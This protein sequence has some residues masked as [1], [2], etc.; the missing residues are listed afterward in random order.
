M[1]GGSPWRR[2]LVFSLPL[3]GGEICHLLYGMTDAFILGRVLG[4]GAL[5]AAGAASSFVQLVFG[6]AMGLSSGFTVITAQRIGSGGGEGVRR[7]VAAG[8][9]LS[10]ILSLVFTAVLIPL[11]RP[12]L[13]LMNTP[14]EIL[15]DAAAYA[16]IIIGGITVSM[17]N[18]LFGG[19][20][21]AS[22]DSLTPLA[23]L[24]VS[25]I[26]NILL[27]VLLVAVIPWGV[28]GAALATVFSQL[29]SAGLALRVLRGRL[30]NLLPR[31]GEWYVGG[32]E[33]GAH[34]S[35]GISMAFQR[36]IVEFGNILVQAVMNRLGTVTIGAVSAAQK[37]RA[38]NMMPFFAVSRAVT[39]YTAQNYGAGRM[40][41]VRRGV[42]QTCLLCLGGGLCM[43]LLNRMGG[44][45]FASLFIRDSAEGAALAYRYIIFSGYTVTILGLMLTF[46]SSLQGM[47]KHLGPVMSGVLE[48]VMSVLAAFVL[49]PRIGFLGLCLVNPLSW[50]A[51]LFPVFLGFLRRGKGPRS[52]QCPS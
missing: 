6:L 46:R 34:F 15:G 12:A 9:I 4:I 32:G 20:I 7:S 13:R 48:T 49:I 33:L 38:L 52:A 3:L 25:S 47:G 30:G 35:L 39:T 45:F 8:I 16:S 44:R 19:I 50:L 36:I 24:I 17:F 21:Q 42:L 31:R 14:A 11:T 23:F 26:L 29:V 22:G 5:A 18:N 28:R 41:R 2:I 43:A 37:I 10:L 1:T 40:D 27:D 51:S